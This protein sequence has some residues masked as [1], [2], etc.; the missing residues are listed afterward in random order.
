[1]HSPLALMSKHWAM[2]V[3][4][5]SRVQSTSCCTCKGYELHISSTLV[6]RVSWTLGWGLGGVIYVTKVSRADRILTDTY[7]ISLASLIHNWGET[8]KSLY[9]QP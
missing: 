9:Q 3:T 6:L 4:V 1:M 8:Y 5:R 2:Y 7:C